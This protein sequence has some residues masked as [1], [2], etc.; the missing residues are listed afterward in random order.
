MY[1]TRLITSDLGD[2]P[3]RGTGSVAGSSEQTSRITW[4]ISRSSD[5]ACGRDVPFVRSQT[6][7]PSSRDRSPEK[8]STG[9]RSDNPLSRAGPKPV[10]AS[11]TMASV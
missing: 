6:E 9:P 10:G 2:R 5:R 1:P 4:R 8:G 7:M 11:I 3:T